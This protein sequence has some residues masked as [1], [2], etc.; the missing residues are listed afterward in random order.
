MNDRERQSAEMR[1][2]RDQGWS[3]A[4]IARH[5][6]V[7]PSTVSKRLN[8]ER[9]ELYKRR[10][11][12]GTL[13]SHEADTAEMYRLS[14]LGWT[15][16]EIGGRYGITQTSVSERLCRYR[17]S[18]PTTIREDVL[19]RELDILEEMRRPLLKLVSE[20][21]PPAYSNGRPMV[22]EQGKAVPDWSVTVSAVRAVLATQDR[23]A[24][25]MGLDQPAKTET[26]VHVEAATAAAK[27][28]ADAAAA[29]LVGEPSLN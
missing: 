24:K 2:Q 28:E 8:P 1:A 19:R 15:Q 7:S 29:F 27:A 21:P 17:K 11:D 5:H 9:G 18:L 22:D 25:F 4:K 16:A 12:G 23:L 20:D 6:G 26:L 10:P 3:Y 14:I 13:P